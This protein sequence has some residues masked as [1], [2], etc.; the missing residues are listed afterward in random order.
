M[1]RCGE[2]MLCCRLLP[3]HDSHNQPE[4]DERMIALRLAKRGVAAFEKPAGERCPHERHTGCT[5][6]NK[7]PIGCQVWNCRWLVN[8]DTGD[9]RRPD[10]A[11]YVIDITPDF[12]T[13]QARDDPPRNIQVVQIWIDPRRPD[14]W[15]QD[16]ALL[17]YLDRR[18]Q[19]G[20][21][22]LMRFNPRDAVTV[23]PPSMSTD[24]CW[25]EQGGR[26]DVERTAE[27]RLAGLAT[28]GMVKVGGD[29]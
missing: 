12:V 15:R 25:H 4:R 20:T 23:F 24:G 18:G 14:A 29:A 2:C 21:A 28:A 8:N 7:R 10:R 9:L 22:A 16:K 19:E 6:Y 11:G 17:A 13:L 1:R 27:E 26:A 3:M 5:I